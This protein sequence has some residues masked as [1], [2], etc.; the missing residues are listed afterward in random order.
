VQGSR[1]LKDSA[2]PIALVVEASTSSSSIHGRSY[3]RLYQFSFTVVRPFILVALYLA[4]IY[5]AKIVFVF[6]R[7]SHDTNE[8]LQ[9]NGSISQRRYF[10]VLALA[11]IDILLTLPLGI[12]TTASEILEDIR[13]PQALPGFPFRS[14]SSWTT[15][16]SNHDPIAF[17]YAMWTS[18]GI[19]SR[20]EL[21][22]QFWISPVLA[23]AIF[24]LFGFTS[25]ARSAYWRAFCTV[26]KL[27][28]W[29]PP[30]PGDEELGEIEFGARQLTM[31]ERSAP[32]R[33]ILRRMFQLISFLLG[34]A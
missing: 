18:T 29:T 33:N 26:A 4:H 19:L 30:I 10:R 15:A 5:Q 3:Y 32:C 8:F 1:Y 27:I 31:T 7:H 22:F 9:T 14:S 21:Y 20:F 6:Y 13:S 2:V 12:I 34:R 25:E 11:C 16:H 17:S 28:G 24:A 23:I